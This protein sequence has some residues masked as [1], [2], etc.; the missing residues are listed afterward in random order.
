MTAAEFRA[1]HTDA[2]KLAAEK[3]RRGMDKV[4]KAERARLKKEAKVLADRQFA[5]VCNRAGL[6]YPQAEHE[7]HPDRKWRID[8]L[9]RRKGVAVGLEVEGGIWKKHATGFQG[10]RH[11]S[12]T[13]F[14]KDIEK[15]NAAAALGITIVRCTPDKLYT[16]GIAAVKA[17]F[18]HHEGERVTD[19][20]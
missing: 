17:V 13:G 12:P 15:Y 4:E 10:G 18:D 8:Y 7:F 11:N 20:E 2:G 5:T 16:E 3:K 1:E 6:P 14:L 19:G 9:F